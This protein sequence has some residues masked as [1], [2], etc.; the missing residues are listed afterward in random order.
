MQKRGFDICTW[1]SGQRKTL[2]MELHI[3]WG[4]GRDLDVE[5]EL[6]VR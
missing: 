2:I 3:A 4:V 6:E 1:S 5:P